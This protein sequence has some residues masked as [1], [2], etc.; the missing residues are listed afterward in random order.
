MHLP[1]PEVFNPD[2][3]IPAGRGPAAETAVQRQGGDTVTGRADGLHF[4]VAQSVEQVIEA[5]RLVFD[6]CHRAG[7]IAYNEH[8]LHFTRPAATGRSAIILGSI[9]GLAVSTLTAVAD[10]ADPPRSDGDGNTGGD[11]R[12]GGLALDHT[13]GPQLDVLRRQ[14][15]RLMEVGL[16]ADR[17]RHLSRTTESLLQLMRYAF[18]FGLAQGVTDF[19]IAVCPRHRRFY[20]RFLGLEAIGEPLPRK[21]PSGAG[22]DGAACEPVLLM[23]GDINE[24]LNRQPLHPALAWF[25]QHPIPAAAFAGRFGFEPEMIAHTPIAAV[26]AAMQSPDDQA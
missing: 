1:M 20:E 25:M 2:R 5:W 17:R 26:L 24:R 9:R 10:D 14:G 13:F 4:T 15:R 18:H 12:G 21:G 11:A 3:P 7:L 23:R 8:R 19:V 16:F 22:R 6:A